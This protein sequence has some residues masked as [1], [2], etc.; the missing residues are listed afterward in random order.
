MSEFAANI[1]A[2]LAVL[3]E[4]ST[5]HHRRIG[6]I[7]KIGDKNTGDISVLMVSVATLNQTVR[8]LSKIVF[9]CAGVLGVAF[10]AALFEIVLKQK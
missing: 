9:G 7:Q 8:L 5:E 1:D 4:K 6:D 10:M 2:K 3:D